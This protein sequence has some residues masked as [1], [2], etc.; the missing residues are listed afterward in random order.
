MGQPGQHADE[1][2]GD[3]FY[4][5]HCAVTDSVLNNPGYT[6][7]AAS[8][9]EPA[10]LDAAFHYPPYE[11]PIDLWKDLP[12]PARAPR[13]LARTNHPKGGVWVAHSA[14]LAKD[15]VG[16]DRSYFSHLLLL[17][18]ADPAA[19]LRSWG[20]EDWVTH[21]RPVRRRNYTPALRLPVGE[22]VSDA[23][24]T[25]FLN[26]DPDGPT[27]LSATV[28]PARLRANTD[29]RRDLFARALHSLLLLAEEENEARRRLYL[30]AEPGLVA[31]LLYGCV[32]L[33]PPAVVNGLTFSTFE[34][35]HRNIR[36][37]KLAE[38][39]GTYL[40]SPDRGLDP[41]L[42]TA[43]GIAL[44]TFALNR[45]SPELRS[46]PPD[47]V[48]A[49]VDLVAA[50]DWDLLPMVRHAI[51]EDPSGLHRAEA[52][53]ARARGLARID[54]G[55]ATVDD[56]LAL[57]RDPIAAEELKSR[58]DRVWPVIKPAVLARPDVRAAFR[59]LIAAPD[60]VRE[61]WEEAV[62]AV[63]KED[64]RAW[65]VRWA[66][67]R[68][69]A[70]TDEAAR[71]LD[72][73]VSSE[74]NEARLA[75]FPATI[76]DKL[77]QACAD[78]NLFPSRP[79]LVPAEPG[80]LDALLRAPPAWA[81]YTALVLLAPDHLNW[82]AHLPAD[83]RG[84]MRAR[85]RAYLLAAPPAAVAAYVR[86]ARALPDTNPASLAS[87]FAPYSATTAALMDGLLGSHELQPA[88]WM[89][90]CEAVGLERGAWARSC[91]KSRGWRTCSSG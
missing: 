1:P 75:K 59:E 88:D 37:Y 82:A 47:G 54:A 62:D 20:A 64:F 11:L 21:Y 10:A 52:A 67:V 43:R 5:T 18:D 70:G 41:D 44:D 61:I 65:D 86:A 87:L 57:Q 35:Y 9:T 23:A 71:R 63:L 2:G 76:R 19:V 73:V 30:L 6:V 26:D 12:P 40:G 14:Y 55:A 24:L 13:R 39:V 58:A 79:L 89:A 15:T 25:A 33:L 31:L 91:S 4:V 68:E 56:L 32:R 53:L 36:D 17:P 16:R 84:P 42:A 81:G 72:R 3:Q 80:E 28:C 78:V 83:A 45:S 27:E 34:A 66:V 77:R 60:R 85:A 74:K 50:G 51:G 7:R 8:A 29:A 49:L 90:L 46:P 22:L 48:S 69:A 38:V